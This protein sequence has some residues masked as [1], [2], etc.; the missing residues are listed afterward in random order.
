[1]NKKLLNIVIIG[2]LVV[3]LGT[4]TML[5]MKKGPDGP[6]PPPPHHGPHGGPIEMFLKNEVKFSDDQMAD[7]RAARI[8]HQQTVE[9][10]HLQG[11]KLRKQQFE[12]IGQPDGKAKADSIADLIGQNTAAMEGS[13]F[14]H[15]NSIRDLCTSE[16]QQ[17]FDQ[18]IQDI[19]KRAEPGPPPGG[20]HGGP[21]HRH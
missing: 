4:L 16:Q 20:H 7:F 21:P 14:D 9:P 13:V 10:L 1:M 19:L 15:F 5:W 6:P 2:L 18:L 11:R 8:R 17:I 12:L 3:N